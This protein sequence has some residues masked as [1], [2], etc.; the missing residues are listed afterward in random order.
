MFGTVGGQT[1]TPTRSTIRP[2]GTGVRRRLPPQHQ[3]ADRCLRG[4]C[5]H[6]HRHHRAGSTGTGSVNSYS[7]GGLCELRGRPRLCETVSWAYAYNDETLTRTIGFPGFATTMARGPL[8]RGDQLLASI[9]A[10]R[11][12]DLADKFIATPFVGVHASVLEAGARHRDRRRYAQSDGQFPEPQQCPHRDGQPARS[13]ESISAS[14]PRS[15][16]AS[17]SA[18]R[19][20]SPTRH[21]PVDPRASAACRPAATR[22]RPPSRGATARWSGVG[23]SS[24]IDPARQASMCAMTA[25]IK[26]PA[27]TP[28]AVIGGVRFTW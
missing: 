20:T 13:R 15:A 19:T 26:R 25:T 6:R 18:G 14:A 10:G 21:G 12:Y 5:R 28:M 24:K 23:V 11:S 27:T 22:C 16:S 3:L 9:E 17:S 8:S 7:W 2:G 1:A 4:L